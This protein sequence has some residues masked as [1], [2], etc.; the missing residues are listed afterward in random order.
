MKTFLRL[1][2]SLVAVVAAFTMVRVDAHDQPNA[3]AGHPP[4][5]RCIP[6]AAEG[7]NSEGSEFKMTIVVG[8]FVL[9]AAVNRLCRVPA[10]V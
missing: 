2:Y 3:T 1:I 10:I 9:I 8:D 4:G 5:N 7:S 6:M